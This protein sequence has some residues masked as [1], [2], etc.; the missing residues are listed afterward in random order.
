MSEIILKKPTMEY[1]DEIEDNIFFVEG[2]QGA[3]KSTF[4]QKLS[5]ELTDYEVFCEGDYSPVELAWCAYVTEEQYNKILKKYPSLSEEI[6]QKTV[7]EGEHRIIC[8]TKILTD[9][10]NFHRDLETYEIYNGNLDKESFENLILSRF[11]K[12]DGERQIFECSIFQNIIENQM[13]FFMMSDDEILEFYRKLKKVLMNK[14]FRIIYLDVDDIS[15]TIDIIRKER[16]DNNGNELWFP[17]MIK[18]VEESPYGRK[19][20]L[21]GLDGLLEH[22]AM[23]RALEHRIINEI[24]KEHACIIKSK[25]YNL[26]DVM[27]HMVKTI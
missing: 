3:G 13:L 21:T 5:A 4:V 14:P 16:S 19:H 17:L 10:P 9:V 8:Y 7:K 1:A 20:A 25:K 18:Y 6:K 23:R 15:G 2:L 24:F 12:W 26:K 27:Q 22:L 11:E